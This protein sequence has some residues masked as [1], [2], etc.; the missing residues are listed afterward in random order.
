[1]AEITVKICSGTTCFI[2]SGNKLNEL[3]EM[4]KS[5]YGDKV[6]VLG[7]NCLGQCSNSHSKAPYIKI[8]DDIIS[9]VTPEKLMIEIEKRITGN[10]K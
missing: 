4:I 7:S 9:E 10:D 1:M 5:K 2:M 3:A 6:E 8:N